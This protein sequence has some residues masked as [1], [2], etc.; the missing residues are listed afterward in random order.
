M[1]RARFVGLGLV[2]AIATWLLLA[3]P[4]RVLGVDAGNAGV[5]MLMAVGWGALYAISRIPDGGLGESMSPG[6]WHAWLGLAF[7]LVIGAYA[8]VH[9]HVFQGPPLWRNPD[10]NR[11]GRN[12]VMLLIAWT[13]LSRVLD[14]RWRSTV[15]RDER[16]R[17][18]DARAT[19]WARITLV[20]V[21][22]AY[23]VLFSFSPTERLAWAPPP[24]IGHLLIVA[25]IASCAV[26]YLATALGYWRDRH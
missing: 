9:A 23:A 11:V 25:L 7:T 8:I 22:I 3:G 18:I 19:E 5:F 20:V 13:I 21:L 16:D 12:I 2:A 24:M 26:E 10:A 1:Q 15:Q 14:A 6:E 17:Q 4:E